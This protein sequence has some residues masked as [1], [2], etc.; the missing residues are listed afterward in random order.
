MINEPIVPRSRLGFIIPSGNRLAE[1]QFQYFAPE[2]VVPHFM[3]LRMAGKHLMPMAELLPRVEEAAAVLGDAKCDVNVLQCTGT[4]MSGGFG[5]EQGIIA[6]MERVTGRPALTTATCL[7]AALTALGA[8]R[9]VFIS[10]NPEPGHAKKRQF[11]VDAGYDI[12]AERAAGLT[13]SD[14]SCTTPPAFWADLARG[15]RT[16][17][18]DVYFISCANIQAIHVIEELEAELNRPVVTSNQVALWHA[19]RTVGISDEIAGL[20]QLMRFG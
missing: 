15:L 13:G 4:S 20:G 19:L 9:L 8:R 5:A 1:P 14:E 7:M 17:K 18:A 6:A 12:V 2:G 3:R 16:P 10:E 11:L